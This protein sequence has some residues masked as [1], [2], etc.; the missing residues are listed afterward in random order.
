MSTSPL[1]LIVDSD[2]ALRA[3]ARALG[4][5]LSV[6]EG[7]R[8]RVRVVMLEGV[9]DEAREVAGGVAWVWA[10][11]GSDGLRAALASLRDRAMPVMLTRLD[12]AAPATRELEPV[13]RC[14]RDAPAEV[15]GAM[16]HALLSQSRLIGELGHEVRLLRQGR[17]ELCDAMH[18][19]DEEMRLAAKLQRQFLPEQMPSVNGV[20]FHALW[21]PATHCSGDLYDVQRL[22]EHHLAFFLADAVGHGVPAALMTVYMERSL[23]TKETDPDDPRGYRLIEPCEVLADL[24]RELLGYGGEDVRFATAVYG[25]IDTRRGRACLARAGH[26]YPLLVRADGSV[27]RIQ[28]DGGLL[29]AFD[30]ETYQQCYLD[31]RPGDRLLIYSDGFEVALPGRDVACLEAELAGLAHGDPCQALTAMAAK[32]D[33]EAGSLHPRDDVTALCLAMEAVEALGPVGSICEATQPDRYA[34]PG[35]RRR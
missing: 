34:D 35:P 26:P 20:S 17:D 18:H 10:A 14:A 8:P 24:N 15:A 33:G 22:D 3:G 19:M 11:N 13:T 7:R 5:V 31:L 32:L 25:V 9:A 6:M 12:D 16:L 4:R 23:R 28:P 29:G 30:G 1:L 27:Q 2:A 21:R